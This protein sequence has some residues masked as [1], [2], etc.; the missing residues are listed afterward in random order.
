MAQRLF[1]GLGL[2]L[3]QASLARWGFGRFGASGPSASAQVPSR[4]PGHRRRG[5]GAGPA[6]PAM[7]DRHGYRENAPEAIAIS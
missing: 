1:A 6:E 4:C 7:G 5:P 2:L 3:C